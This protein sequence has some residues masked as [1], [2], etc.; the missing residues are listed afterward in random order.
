M[1][2]FKTYFCVSHRTR[3]YSLHL[4]TV[5]C[6]SI[7]LLWGFITYI[8]KHDLKIFSFGRGGRIQI[9]INIYNNLQILVLLNVLRNGG[10][11]PFPSYVITFFNYKKYTILSFKKFKNW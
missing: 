11:T 5:G 8:F 2:I 4:L 9:L 6:S 3:T 10:G 1:A 7:E